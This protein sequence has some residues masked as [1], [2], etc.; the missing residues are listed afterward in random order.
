M[1]M[2]RHRAPRDWFK[3]GLVVGTTLLVAYV[4]WGTRWVEL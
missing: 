1:T 4:V 3:I 2:G